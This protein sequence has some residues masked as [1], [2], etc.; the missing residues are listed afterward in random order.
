LISLI[1]VFG[2]IAAVFGSIQIHKVSAEIGE[3]AQRDLL[4]G[5]FIARMSLRQLE[6]EILLHGAVRYGELGVRD[7]EALERV[8]QAAQGFAQVGEGM[9][10]ELREYQDM[11]AT[12]AEEVRR[13][14]S[15]EEFE[16]VVERLNAVAGLLEEYGQSG[17]KAFSLIS[18]GKSREARTLL[19]NI[20]DTKTQ[21][22]AELNA[23]AEQMERFVRTRAA[24]A[25]KDERAA[26]I[27]LWGLS[28]LAVALGLVLGILIA[29]RASRAISERARQLRHQEARTRSI[30]NSTAD[31]IITIDERGTVRSFN[32]SAERMFGYRAEEVIGKNV[33]MLAP[34]PYRDEHDGYL[35]RYLRSDEARIVGRE[36]DLEGQRKDGTRFPMSLRVTEVEDGRDRMFIGTVQDISERKRAEK[37]LRESERKYRTIFEAAPGGIC[38]T[39]QD[40]RILDANQS[41][42]DLFGYTRE[43]ITGLN[44]EDFYVDP[45]NRVRFQRAMEAEGRVTDFEAKL[46]KKDGTELDCLLTTTVRRDTHGSRSGYLGIVVDVTEQKRVELQLRLSQR[47]EAVGR[48]AGGVAHDFNNVLMAIMGSSELLL[49][50]LGD[51]HPGRAEVHQIQHAA[52]RAA[53]LTRQLLAFARRELV[54]PRVLNLNAVVADAEKMLRR[55][56]GEDIQ[57]VT[58]LQHELWSVKADPGQ[59]EQVIVNL[60]VNARDAMPEGGQLTLETANVDLDEAYAHQHVPSE[61]GSYVMLAVSDTG[62][63]FDEQTRARIFEPFFTTKEAGKGTGLGLATVYGIVKQAGGYI[64]VYSE[65]GH[66]STFKVYLPRVDV[67][68]DVPEEV[69]RPAVA[70]AAGEVLRGT[71]TVLVVEDESA[72]RALLCEFLRRY[73]YTVLEASHAT[74][75]LDI[76]S[77]HDGRIGLLVTDVVMPRISGP[78]LAEQL[79]L[80]RPGLKVLYVSGYAD[81]AIVEHGMVRAQEAYLQK[82][83]PPDVLLRKVRELLGKS[84]E[85]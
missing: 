22:S 73:G 11:A 15:R 55:L 38:V 67:G 42:L 14:A 62:R 56:I 71:E 20:D 24:Q 27:A 51:T 9:A 76:S 50:D 60:V 25:R 64:W 70:D 74:E 79:M 75:A 58:V 40:G 45:A 81:R 65:P 31:G 46:R 68:V 8:R 26:F 36:R 82:P 72:V 57:L 44:A 52:R 43:E 49:S 29:R 32:R 18:A 61:P 53:D 3:I 54:E 66:G 12:A 39:G 16:Y 48:L 69:S 7:T 80:S 47:L 5:R 85:C 30:L 77:R 1:L 84:Q 13:R 4:L 33:K 10:E 21:L 23:L 78:E 41:F 2:S 59:I 35:D 28:A 6:R 63:G 83:F 37:A 17:E 19:E 34:S